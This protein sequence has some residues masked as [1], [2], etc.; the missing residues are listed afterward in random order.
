MPEHDV[1][2]LTRPGL[3]TR[4]PICFTLLAG[5]GSQQ[6]CFGGPIRLICLEGVGGVGARPASPRRDR[7]MLSALG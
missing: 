1:A 2:G 4:L 6:R 3:L 5:D 7:C